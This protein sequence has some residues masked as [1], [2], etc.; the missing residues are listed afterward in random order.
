[1]K[2]PMPAAFPALRRAFA[3]YLHEDFLVEAGSP[4]SALRAF[5]ADAT[6]AERRQF[7]REAARFLVQ[8]AALD[9][10]E[11]HEVLQ[12]LGSRWIPT[13]RDAFMAL[14]ASVAELPEP[15]AR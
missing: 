11:L 8:A 5:L 3:G 12:Q 13:S 4:E 9:L 14:L 10:A 2:R 15:R 7:R 1:M 6:P